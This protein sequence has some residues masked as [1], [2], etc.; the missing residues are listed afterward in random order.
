MRLSYD[1]PKWI[2]ARHGLPAALARNL[3]AIRPLVHEA[4][5]GGTM[6]TVVPSPTRRWAASPAAP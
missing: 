5:T 1:A 3:D 6:L 2:A 4:A